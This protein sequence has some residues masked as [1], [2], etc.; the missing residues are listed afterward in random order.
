M[1]KPVLAAVLVALTG[2]AL[3]ST[4]GDTAT[5]TQRSD[6]ATQIDRLAAVADDPDVIA[7]RGPGYGFTLVTRKTIKRLVFAL[8]LAYLADSKSGDKIVDRLVEESGLGLFEGAAVKS[9]ARQT[10]GGD[11][12]ATK[13]AIDL[14]MAQGHRKIDRLLDKAKAAGGDNAL[15]C[16]GIASGLALDD[17][18]P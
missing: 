14:F 10:L 9:M 18:A 7:V 4:G 2:P 8:Q 1:M 12:K 13:L 6:C 11:P 3:A 17:S 15:L 16:E 5:P